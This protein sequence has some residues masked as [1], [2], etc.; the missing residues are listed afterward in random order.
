MC[1]T[2]PCLPPRYQGTVVFYHSRGFFFPPHPMLL[3]SHS[4]SQVASVIMNIF[5]EKILS[6]SWLFGGWIYAYINYVYKYLFKYR[7]TFYIPYALNEYQSNEK[8]KGYLF[9]A[10]SSKGISPTIC[11]W[12]DTQTSMGGGKVLWWRQ[13]GAMHAVFRGFC[14]EEAGIRKLET[15]HPWGLDRGEYLALRWV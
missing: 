13:E 7:Q 2:I 6:N 4:L 10:H 11:N 1:V 14:W 12:A 5:M 9:G 15:G 8:R 3:T